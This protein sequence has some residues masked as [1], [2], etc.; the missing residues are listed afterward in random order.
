MQFGPHYI[1][2]FAHH[3]DGAIA[4]VMGLAIFVLF[5]AIG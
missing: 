3:E 2:K 1:K 4:V 5:G